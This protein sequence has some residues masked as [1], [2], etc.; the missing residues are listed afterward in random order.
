MGWLVQNGLPEGK[1]ADT[2]PWVD[3]TNEAQCIET[4][5]VSVERAEEE[6]AAD[7]PDPVLSFNIYIHIHAKS[8]LRAV[9]AR[10]SSYSHEVNTKRYLNV[11]VPD[12]GYHCTFA[13]GA[14][15][16]ARQRCWP[17]SQASIQ[18]GTERLELPAAHSDHVRKRA[19]AM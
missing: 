10:R 19:L 5:K 12:T 17:H 2:R 16:L 18:Y 4:H 13:A 1:K 9:L 11:E 3:L 15:V 8:G 7:R 14:V 6:N